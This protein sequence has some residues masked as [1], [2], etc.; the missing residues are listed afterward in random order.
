MD[1][2]VNKLSM[3]SIV[4]EIEVAAKYKLSE[5]YLLVKIGRAK[6]LSQEDMNFPNPYVV[7]D[8]YLKRYM[9]FYFIEIL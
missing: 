7:I 6:G 3:R 8:L 4:G 5:K 2:T 1:P 9:L